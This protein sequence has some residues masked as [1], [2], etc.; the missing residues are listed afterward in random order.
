MINEL[1]CCPTRSDNVYLANDEKASIAVFIAV[2]CFTLLP[3]R[4]NNV[5]TCQT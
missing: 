4:G 5:Y 3:S 2:F 1:E